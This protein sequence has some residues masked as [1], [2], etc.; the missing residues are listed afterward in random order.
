[1]MRFIF[2]SVLL[3]ISITVFA[4]PRVVTTTNKKAIKHFEQAMQDLREGKR[5]FAIDALNKAVEQDENFIEALIVRGDV[6]GELLDYKAASQSYEEVISRNPDFY[7]EAYLKAAKNRFLMEDYETADVHVKDYLEVAKRNPKFD[8]PAKYLARNTAFALQA[9]KNPVPFDPINLGPEVNSKF[10]EYY[11]CL[12]AD[13]QTIFFTRNVGDERAVQEDFY[14]ADKDNDQWQKAYPI[15][16]HI[17]T[18]RNEGAPTIT[19]NG[20]FM[21]FTIC[22]LYG[23]RDYGA[24]REGYGSCDLFMSFRQGDSW[25]KPYNVGPEVNTS[26]W[27]TQP[28]LSGD[29]RTLYFIRGDRNKPQAERKQNIYVSHLQDNGYFSVAKPLPSPVNTDGKESSVMIHPDGRTLYFASTGHPGFGGEDLFMTQLQPDGTWLEPKNLGY[30]INTVNNENSLMVSAKGDVAYFASNREGGY[31]FLD[32]YKFKLPKEI[33]PNPVTYTKGVVVDAETGEKLQAIFK[34]DDV[35]SKETVVMQ[36]S[37]KG[38]GEFLVILPTGKEYALSIE[39]EGYLFYSENFELTEPSNATEPQEIEVKLTP[40]KSG[41]T[42]V[43][44]NIFFET[45][46]FDLKQKSEVELDKLFTFLTNNSTLN[47]EIGGHTDNV[48]STEDNQLLSQN[49]AKSV[50]DYLISKGID[51]ARLSY[52]GYGESMPI[53]TND[54]EEGRAQNRRTEFKIL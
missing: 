18:N 35:I 53:A 44:K 28:S 27:E 54:T 30:P 11:P 17:N 23:D 51:A 34:L 7:A 4:Q 45:N 14:V 15:P 39:K 1:M 48:G 19:S 32:L 5:D 20:N 21:V 3:L 33:K 49:R 29:G 31:G 9:I 52:K 2:S 24:D 47:I 12:T 43:L 25:T 36:Q 22:E 8:A 46:K 37:E 10:S 13:D 26:N 42:V 6:Y 16:G 38:T 40:I 50:A 41:K